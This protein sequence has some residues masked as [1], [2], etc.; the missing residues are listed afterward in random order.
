MGAAESQPSAA[1]A[2]TTETAAA[3]AAAGSPPEST[4]V[5]VFFV[6]ASWCGACTATKPHW[7]AFVG[8]HPGLRTEYIDIDAVQPGEQE[9]YAGMTEAFPTFFYVYADGHEERVV[10][11]RDADQLHALLTAA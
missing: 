1:T 9:R 8:S 10:G 3:A 4:V 5:A 2:V 7:Q 11:M 6:G